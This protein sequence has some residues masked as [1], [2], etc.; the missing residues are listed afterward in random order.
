[1]LSWV[2]WVLF[3]VVFVVLRNK[4]KVS[5]VHQADSLPL[6]QIRSPPPTP[7]PRILRCG[8]RKECYRKAKVKAARLL[9]WC[10]DTPALLCSAVL[11]IV[12]AVNLTVTLYKAGPS[13]LQPRLSFV[14]DR[15]RA[16]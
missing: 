6:G 7:S 4:P 2:G 16:I 14:S 9:G 10:R 11:V 1:M 15:G 3:S 5:C 13:G 8:C 12:P